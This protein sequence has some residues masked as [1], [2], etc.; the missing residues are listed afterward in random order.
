MLPPDVAI[1][2]AVTLGIGQIDLLGRTT[3]GLGVD[4]DRTVLGSSPETGT[5]TVTIEQ[6]IGRIRVTR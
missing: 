6:G 4:A 1:S 3:G 5:L 2:V